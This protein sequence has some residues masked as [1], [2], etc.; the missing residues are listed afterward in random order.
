MAQPLVA[1]D[2][3]GTPAIISYNIPEPTSYSGRHVIELKLAADAFTEVV[4]VPPA[5]PA[6]TLASPA[7]NAS[8]V[9][10]GH[11]Q[12]VAPAGD[13]GSSLPLWSSPGRTVTA[14]IVAPEGVVLT[15]GEPDASPIRSSLRPLSDRLRA[16]TN[17][18][19]QAASSA[20]RQVVVYPNISG[21][22]DYMTPEVRTIDAVG[23][24]ATLLDGNGLA[25]RDGLLDGHIDPIG[26][27]VDIWIDS[28]A[29]GSPLAGSAEGV[30]VPV[31][32][33]AIAEAVTSVNISVALDGNEL[34]GA[35]TLQAGTWSTSVTIKSSGQHTISVTIT[36]TGPNRL[37]RRPQTVTAD[38]SVTVAVD[39]D[40]GNPDP[41]PVLPT[42]T[43]TTPRDNSI[44]NS[45]DGVAQQAV[46]G[47]ASC[48]PGRSIQKILVTN[49]GTGDVVELSASGQSAPWSTGLLLSGVGT[50]RIT[51]RVRDDIGQISAPHSVSVR[52]TTV[53]PF[54]RIRNRLMLIE[55]L[56]IS[57]FLGSFGAGRVIKTFSLLPGEKTTISVKSWTKST[58]SRKEGASIVDSDATEAAES[59]EDA[60]NAEQSHK[61]AN[62][63]STNYSIEG[64]ASASWGWG[65]ASLGASQ[66]GAANSAREQAVKN[67][68]NA[69]RKHSMKASSNRNVTINT[70]Y[71]ATQEEGT[72]AST[73]RE[74]A[75]INV[76]RTLNFV[77]RQMNQKHFTL[78]HLTD[79]RIAHYAE[80]WML[81]GAGNLAYVQ[82]ATTGMQVPDIRS[83]YTE[84]PLPE[85]PG[86]LENVITSKY[87][88]QITD[89]IIA[90]LSGIPDHEGNATNAVEEVAPKDEEGEPIPNAEYLRFPPPAKLSQTFKDGH[91]EFTVP[92][93]LLGVNSV[94]MRT[95]AVMVDTVLGVGSGLD[96]YSEGLQTIA[97]KER[98]VALAERQAEVDRLALARSL[99]QQKD[100]ERAAIFAMVF[101]S[102]AEDELGKGHP[103]R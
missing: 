60:I 93:I 65:T 98:E 101:P 50:H 39:L 17:A 92:G 100:K 67:V 19:V 10:A 15:A 37:L 41:A 84:V 11:T 97:L 27:Q 59:F 9:E 28:P 80:D 95:D 99:V 91:H 88:R 64:K 79:A 76:S 5:A 61:E 8:M 68:S 3:E 51:A 52:L 4:M 55:T 58:E 13:N 46:E 71:T 70:E 81:D 57:S 75:N 38:A 42:V 69:T 44:L 96:T 33:G 32:G 89:A 16:L 7:G 54:R 20:G 1:L 34:P 74:I 24:A 43:I 83:T 29:S 66:S 82:D 40:T 86:L 35:I 14:S 90:A 45:P 12:T 63:E 49:E 103:Q 47:T 25:A 85:L 53:E 2:P 56:N 31:S 102:P 23:P 36:G 73:V 87:H 21:Q 62:S 26:P 6:S 22:L 72:E 77:F 94:V 48:G 78:M 30:V 18:D